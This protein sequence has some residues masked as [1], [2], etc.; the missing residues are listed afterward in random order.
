LRP[1]D[2]ASAG[3]ANAAV[4]EERD[5]ARIGVREAVERCLLPI[6]ALPEDRLM[7]RLRGNAPRYN[8]DV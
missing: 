3:A 7:Y 5:T 4:G 6:T 1:G 2:T 8:L